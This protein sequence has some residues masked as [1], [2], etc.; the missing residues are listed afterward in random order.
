[1]AALITCTKKHI[2]NIKYF[3]NSNG[4]LGTDILLIVIFSVKFCFKYNITVKIKKKIIGIFKIHWNTSFNLT[5][6]IYQHET[7]FESPT[8]AI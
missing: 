6:Y 2:A 8:F 3:E 7:P 4:V 5:N 1:M